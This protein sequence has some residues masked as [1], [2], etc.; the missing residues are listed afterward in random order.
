MIEELEVYNYLRSVDCCRVCCLRFL[1]GRADDFINIEDA[2]EKRNISSSS[3]GQGSPPKKVRENTCVAC[4]G[5][6]ESELLE[7]LLTEICSSASFKEYDCQAFSSSISLPLVLHLRQLSLWIDLLERFPNR[8]DNSSSPPDV[9]VKDAFKMILNRKLEEKLKRPFS[10]NGV[11][12][13][14]FF[15]Y[16][17]EERE[18]LLLE[19]VKPEVFVDR[20]AKK[21]CRK[22]FLTRNAFEKHFT[23]SN[24]SL[25][26]YREHISVPPAVNDDKLELEMVNFTGPTIFL[27]GRYNKISRELSQTP[28]VIDGKR[29][30]ENSVQEIMASVVAPYFRVPDDSL[31]FS[32]S[33]RED[34]DV[35]CLGEGRPFVLEI[36][37]TY[38]D[39]LQESV[40]AE[41][42]MAI[43]RSKKISVRDLQLVSREELVHIKHG[44]M[45]KR[46]FYR[47]LCVIEK[48]VTV[49]VLQALNV[50]EPFEIEQWTPLRVLHRRPLLSRP[51]TVYSVKASACR[52][53]ERVLIVDIVTQAGTYIK[54]LVHSDFGRTKPSLRSI[55]GQPIDIHALDVMA[56]D[57]DWPKKLR[58]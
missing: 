24:L 54:E 16:A 51:R 52:S 33:G 37:N 56:I 41:M 9:T 8:Y 23:P 47:A 17:D 5:L 32:S 48:P 50:E 14:V 13:N 7:N 44:E 35:R 49:A 3:D 28:W 58:R 53:N 22:E 31:I 39:Y 21:H 15:K 43:E 2:L 26:L 42:E 30:M 20:K 36:P 18:L 19:K 34:V 57:L 27:A 6:F 10:T 55:I 29:K 45:D 40:A 11:M 46:K 1:N 25:K 4:L 38:K 12:V